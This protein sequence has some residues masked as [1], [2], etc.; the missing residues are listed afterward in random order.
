MQIFFTL[1]Y[2]LVRSNKDKLKYA[3]PMNVVAFGVAN[4]NREFCRLNF[5]RCG[6]YLATRPTQIKF[7]CLNNLL[8]CPD[9]E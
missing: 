4:C 9:I 2:M 6:K 3:S 8:A 5:S 1:N 7:L